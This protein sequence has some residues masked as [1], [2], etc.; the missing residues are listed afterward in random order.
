MILGTPPRCAR[1]SWR[2]RRR[3][4]LRAWRGSRPARCGRCPLPSPRR[5]CAA[6]TACR[7]RATTLWAPRAWRARTACRDPQRGSRRDARAP[8]HRRLFSPMPTYVYRFIDTGETIEVRQSFEDE[9]LTQAPHPSD[10]TMRPVKKVFTPVGI[11]FKGSG[12]YKTDSGGAKRSSSAASDTQSSAP[13]DASRPRQRAAL[14]RLQHRRPHHRL[15]R[16]HLHL[17]LHSR[18]K[19]RRCGEHSCQVTAAQRAA[20]ATRRVSRPQT[21]A[22]VRQASQAAQRRHPW[23][24]DPNCS[25]AP[26]TSP[27][28]RCRQGLAHTDSSTRRDHS[29]P[30]ALWRSPIGCGFRRARRWC[31]PATRGGT[32]PC[33]AVRH[34]TDAEQPEIVM[35]VRAARSQ[36]HG[37]A[38][39]RF[40]H[41]LET[42]YVAVKRRT[43]L[44]VANVEHGMVET[45]NRRHAQRLQGGA[46]LSA[47]R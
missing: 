9:P 25:Q 2:D 12:F 4:R 34:V 45:A 23:R 37:A 22:T 3:P 46:R 42:E 20:R 21:N 44:R 13:S 11:T 35:I 26:S 39:G 28:T 18:L 31:P 1:C 16:R 43:A 32:G 10:G 15:L 30:S 19:Q 17:Q 5:W 7:R 14:P 33:L 24:S 36:E 29:R 41:R 27:R 47:G 38:A 6:A 8:T 40:L